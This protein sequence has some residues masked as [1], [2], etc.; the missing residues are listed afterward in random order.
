MRGAKKSIYV[1][2]APH[3]LR[4]IGISLSPEGRVRELERA[5]GHRLELEYQLTPL[6]RRPESQ[7]ERARVVEAWTHFYLSEYR[8]IGEWFEVELERAVQTIARVID[9]HP[10]SLPSLLQKILRDRAAA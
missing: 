4:K 7:G 1:V 6:R 10:R 5:G 3:G 8:V 9:E 2:C